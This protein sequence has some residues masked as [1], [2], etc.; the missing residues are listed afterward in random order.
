[1]IE[2]DI[3]T[4][5]ETAIAELPEQVQ[6]A[7]DEV[8]IIVVENAHDEVL[9][10]DTEWPEDF[11][12]CYIG[13]TIE[14]DDDDEIEAE[15]PVGTIYLNLENLQSQDDVLQTLFHEIGH[16]TGLSEQDVENL[17]LEN[18]SEEKT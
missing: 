12:G 4:I 17:G 18:V 2:Q 11:R 9:P 15:R 1:M 7:L 10:K 16:A 8:S 13:T 3:R 5:V 14:G 6:E